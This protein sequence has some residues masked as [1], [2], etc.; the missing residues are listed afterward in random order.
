[1]KDRLPVPEELLHLLE[2]RQKNERRHK[3]ERRDH[4]FGPL[5]AIESEMDL[6]SIPLEDRRSVKA[7][8]NKGRRRHS[9]E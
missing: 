1:M 8:R 5:G 7:R 4:D 3:R 6:E 2:K 9:D